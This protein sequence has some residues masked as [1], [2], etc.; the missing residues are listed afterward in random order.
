MILSTNE[1]L[2]KI[3][4]T[5][6]GIKA[7]ENATAETLYDVMTQ[8]GSIEDSEKRKTM[9]ERYL[10]KTPIDNRTIQKMQFGQLVTDTDPTIV[11]NKVSAPYESAI[12]KTMVGYILGNPVTTNLSKETYEDAEHK[13]INDLI[14]NFKLKASWDDVNSDMATHAN[15]CGYGV[16]IL[17]S[18]KASLE[19]KEI[20]VYPFEVILFGADYTR[21]DAALRH[22]EISEV[23]GN[24]VKQ[25][26]VLEYYTGTTF[27]Q[28]VKDDNDY[29]EI[30]NTPHGFDGC[31]V[32]GYPINAEAMGRFEKVIS[33]IDANNKLLSDVSSEIEAAHMAQLTIAG[34]PEPRDEAAKEELKQNVLNSKVVLAQD[35]GTKFEWL[36]KEIN[37]EFYRFAFETN[38]K[39]IYS[40]SSTPNMTD[41]SFSNNSSGVALSYKMQSFA[42]DANVQMRKLTRG[43]YR[44]FE[45]IASFYAKQGKGFDAFALE[46]SFNLMEATN[47]K[48]E[49]ENF[50]KTIGFLPLSDS[51]KL[52]SFITDPDKTAREIEES[53]A[54]EL[55]M[56]EEKVEEKVEETPEV[57]TIEG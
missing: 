23:D 51:L 25:K 10:G 45:L 49:I 7:L 41:D 1:L 4:I 35:T 28:Y 40:L 32:I 15:A 22:Y 56:F 42:C 3:E 29:I 53:K 37:P 20:A 17:Y 26:T 13:N 2:D 14:T 12:V 57:E 46:F 43:F 18:P 21:P 19:V 48:E 52:L 38:E 36:I 31:P 30:E 16:K 27:I 8:S 54:N 24:E 34:I 39:E 6:N 55:S 50:V 11:N 9:Y 5:A 47:L 33:L 44:E